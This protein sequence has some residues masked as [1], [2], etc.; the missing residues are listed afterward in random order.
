[1]ANAPTLRKLNRAERALRP[2]N[3]AKQIDEIRAKVDEVI[4]ALANLNINVT[5]SAS[6]TSTMV[7][8][9]KWTGGYSTVA[10]DGVV[11][12]YLRTDTTLVYPEALGTLADR[13]KTLT[14]TESAAYSALLTSSSGF[15]VG[16]KFM[17]GAGK[18]LSLMAP[19][20]TTPFVVGP[21]GTMGRDT[22]L[23][24]TLMF[25][26]IYS[27]SSA[28]KLFGWDLQ[29]LNATG[30]GGIQGA[31]ISVTDSPPSASSVEI[32]GLG[33]TAKP[34]N[35]FQTGDVVGTRS[36]ITIGPGSHG[37]TS[38]FRAKF[39]SNVGGGNTLASASWFQC[40]SGLNIALG[41]VTGANIGFHQPTAFAL[42][43]P[44]RGVR[45]ANSIECTA[46]DVLCST[47]A[48]GFVTKDVQATPEFWRFYTSGTGL[49]GGTIDIDV[50]GFGS[51]TRTAAA[52]GTLTL[53]M[54][55]VGTAAA[56][57]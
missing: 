34:G 18:G 28:I 5:G 36:E 15:A 56:N 50:D 21:L 26:G 45:T 23:D 41:T 33:V 54:V 7:P 17:G 51:A 49:K 53:N 9:D 8:H 3:I 39:P 11:D 31:R 4:Q 27:Q 6:G 46:N 10:A 2:Q 30:L 1:M 55:D 38:P 20:G 13:T 12:K 42:G 48:K 19:G 35:T 40:E 14:L 43:T 25:H 37:A 29:G 52:T 24:T 22:Y 44:R 32:L 16:S 57:T 47:A